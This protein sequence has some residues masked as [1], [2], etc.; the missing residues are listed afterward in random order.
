MVTA[1]NHELNLGQLCRDQLEG[2]NHEFEPLVGSPLPECQNAVSG[3]T[4]PR[5][6]GEFGP[7]REDT[8]RTQMHIIPP[9]LVVQDLAI[10]GHQHGN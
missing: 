8:V 2:L 9:I 6:I 10:T 5:E 4:A 7:A 1:G 3:S